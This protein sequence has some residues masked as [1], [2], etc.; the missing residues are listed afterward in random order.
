MEFS[1]RGSDLDNEG[2][3]SQAVKVASTQLFICRPLHK[4]AFAAGCLTRRAAMRTFGLHGFF[5]PL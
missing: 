3:N 1:L 5:E 4:C 2:V